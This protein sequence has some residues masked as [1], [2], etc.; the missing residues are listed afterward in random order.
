VS[1]LSVEGT[2]TCDRELGTQVTP[3]MVPVQA[4]KARNVFNHFAEDSSLEWG[5]LCTS[6]CTKLFESD[7][8]RPSLTDQQ[9]GFPP[10]TIQGLQR[11]SSYLEELKRSGNQHVA[12]L[13]QQLCGVLGSV[14]PLPVAVPGV[15]KGKAHLCWDTKDQHLELKLSASGVRQWSYLD[16]ATGAKR[17]GTSVDGAIAEFVELLGQITLR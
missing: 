3:W 7:A 17:E 5:Q 16:R 8:V 13:W 4:V 12:A 14:V 6:S 15:E 9:N 2:C 11:W 10:P 1:A